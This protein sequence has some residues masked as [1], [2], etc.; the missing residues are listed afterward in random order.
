MLPFKSWNV[1]TRTIHESCNSGQ[2]NIFCKLIKKL[3]P[4][5]CEFHLRFSIQYPSYSQVGEFQLQLTN[6]PTFKNCIFSK[7][8]FFKSVFVEGVF[9]KSWVKL[10]SSLCLP[11][12]LTNLLT[13]RADTHIC[14]T[15]PYPTPIRSCRRDEEIKRK[16]SEILNKNFQKS[17]SISL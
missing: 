3:D 8:V 11:S 15:L 2:I 1:E 10:R 14:T 5:C 4:K 17:G 6:I 12:Q 7:S 13:F 9:F 16:R